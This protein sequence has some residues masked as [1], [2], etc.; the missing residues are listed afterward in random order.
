ML[1]LSRRTELNKR[2]NKTTIYEKFQFDDKQEKMFDTDVSLV[3]IANEISE[4]SVGVAPGED[5]FSIHVLRVV[6]KSKNYNDSSIIRLFK[7]IGNKVILALEYEDEVQIVAYHTK[8]F[9]TEWQ[10][11]DEATISINGL[12][13]DSIYV[14]LITQ[15]GGFEIEQGRVLDEQIASNEQKAKL[16]KEISRLEKQARNEKQPK[17]KF[18]LVQMIKKLQKEVE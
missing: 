17:K 16:E 6:M 4:Y 15:I 13:L 8:L 5:T 14:N 12:N 1:G 2:I 9:K 10:P 11:I 7:L 18:E 3:Y